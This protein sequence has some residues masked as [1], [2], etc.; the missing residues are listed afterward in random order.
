MLN[1]LP[2]LIIR[3]KRGAND[4][5]QTRKDIAVQK[6]QGKF[7]IGSGDDLFTRLYW[8]RGFESLMI[9]LASDAP[10]SSTDRDV[11]RL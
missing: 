4:W 11:D 5:V 8:L 2:D 7:T 3:A 1:P 6:Q 9:D 10:P